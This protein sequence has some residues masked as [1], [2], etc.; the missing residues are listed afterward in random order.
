MIYISKLND[1]KKDFNELKIW[2]TRLS[3]GFIFFYKGK[4]YYISSIKKILKNP[5][6][7]I[8]IKTL[9]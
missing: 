7:S 5:Q 6:I 2:E 1:K 8:W 4:N 9:N 3:K